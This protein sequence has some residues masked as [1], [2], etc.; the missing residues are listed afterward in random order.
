MLT[1]LETLCIAV[2]TAGCVVALASILIVN[3]F[4]AMRVEAIP[5]CADGVTILK[6]LHGAEPGLYE[7]LLSFVHQDYDGAVQIIL[8]LASATDGAL[9]VALRIIAEHPQR[10]IELVIG[11][12]AFASNRK[13]ANLMGTTATIRHEVVVLSDSDM[14]VDRHYLNRVT[15]ALASPDVGLVTCLYRG[16]PDSGVWARLS[17]MAI[18][19]H[20]L[21]SVLLG[22]H[23]KKARPCMGATMAFSRTTLDAIG[24]FAAFASCLADDYAIGEA[25]RAIGQRVVVGPDVIAHRCTETSL[26]ELFEHELR[27]ARTLRSIDPVGFAGSFITNPLPFAVLAAALFGF[28]AIG[29]ATLL[30]TVLCRF[31]LQWRIERALNIATSRWLLSPA[32]DA[33]SFVVFCA[34]FVV[35][36]VVWRGN[37]YRVSADGT[38]E[39]LK[40]SRS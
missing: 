6:P 3:G 27:W 30:V 20:F 8:G 32:R 34:S 23:L 26:T 39:E 1:L 10:D 29:V 21:P 28:D 2:A 19:Y 37:R 35:T 38:M 36:N 4:D 12:P 24:G 31:A 13:I 15:N 17:S 22:L 5:P 11:S 16:D 40:G 7:N 33:L 14:R 18:D 25:V 9:P